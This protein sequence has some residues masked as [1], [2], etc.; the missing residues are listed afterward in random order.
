ML[1]TLNVAE[2]THFSNT[3]NVIFVMTT[4]LPFAGFTDY[5]TDERLKIRRE[6]TKNEFKS[7]FAE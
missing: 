1:T 3:R 4:I 5:E 2:R 6:V 7:E